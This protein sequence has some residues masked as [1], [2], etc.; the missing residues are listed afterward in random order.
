MNIKVAAFTS[1]YSVESVVL[2][3]SIT[4]GPKIS[5]QVREL[6]KESQQDPSCFVTFPFD[7]SINN[8]SVKQ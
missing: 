7:T 5:D 2:K 6:D 4:C 8:S 3:L 1:V